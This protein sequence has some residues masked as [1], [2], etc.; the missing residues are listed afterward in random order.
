MLLRTYAQDGEVWIDGRHGHVES[1]TRNKLKNKEKSD[2]L[3]SC[4]FFCWG[5]VSRYQ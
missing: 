2:K 3:G 4:R 5:K 1:D